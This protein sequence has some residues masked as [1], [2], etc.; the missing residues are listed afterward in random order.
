MAKI[1][2]NDPC[3]CGSGRKYKKCCLKHGSQGI[4]KLSDMIINF[5]GDFI[6]LARTLQEKQAYLNIA[7]SAW[8]I[9]ILPKQEQE[10][11]IEDF[12]MELQKMNPKGDIDAVKDEFMLLI[13]KKL[14]I[15][16]NEKRIIATAEF[17]DNNGDEKIRIGSYAN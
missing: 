17:V 13:E 8:N 3:P 16:P 14:R 15:Y 7:C 11:A 9:S 10:K 12:G 1:S 2:R 5:A 6:G 4:K